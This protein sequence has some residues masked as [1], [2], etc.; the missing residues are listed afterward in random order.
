MLQGKEQAKDLLRLRLKLKVH[1]RDGCSLPIKIETILIYLQISSY[2][3][4]SLECL[5]SQ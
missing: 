2:F 4:E 1:L 3:Q 5:P